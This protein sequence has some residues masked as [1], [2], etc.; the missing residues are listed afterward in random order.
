MTLLY[1]ESDK[2]VVVSPVKVTAYLNHIICE[3]HTNKRLEVTFPSSVTAK[4]AV[5]KLAKDRY[6]DARKC[7]IRECR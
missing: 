5:I 4:E 7:E 1:K 3:L 6:Y 2:I